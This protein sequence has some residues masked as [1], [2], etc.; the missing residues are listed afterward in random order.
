MLPLQEMQSGCSFTPPKVITVN[1]H[2]LIYGS[3]TRKLVLSNA[4][5]GREV[6]VLEE[7]MKAVRNT[8]HGVL[9]VLW[10]VVVSH[11]G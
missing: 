9:E 3:A 5:F 1:H 8:W 11:L 10:Q 6:L 2:L 4:E 7:R